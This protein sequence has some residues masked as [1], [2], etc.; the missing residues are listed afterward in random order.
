MKSS[1]EGL[2]KPFYLSDMLLTSID[3][4]SGMQEKSYFVCWKLG[5]ILNFDLPSLKTWY[6]YISAEIIG[7][8]GN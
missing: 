1:K 8:N 3:I 6:S 7:F 2:V 4:P 5:Y